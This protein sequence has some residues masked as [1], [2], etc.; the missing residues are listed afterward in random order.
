M[1]S[2]TP[3]IRIPHHAH[4]LV[5]QLFEIIAKQQRN[6]AEISHEVGLHRRTIPAWGQPS[7][8]S[9]PTLINIEA[10]FNALDYDLRAVRRYKP[11]AKIASEE[12]R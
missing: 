1:V 7:R 3:S 4:P 11:K 8:C 6:I 5:R 2:L 9:G 12:W 10:A